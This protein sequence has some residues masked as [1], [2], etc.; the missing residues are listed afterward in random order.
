MECILAPRVRARR[1][2]YLWTTYDLPW[3][4]LQIGGG[5]QCRFEPL[6]RLDPDQCRWRRLPARSAG[7]WIVSAMAKYPL[8]EHVDLQLN[9]TNLTNNRFYDQ[10]HPSHVVPDRAAPRCSA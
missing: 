3:W 7:Y 1:S 5:T 9:L 8:S 6:C 2:G 4:K 10:L